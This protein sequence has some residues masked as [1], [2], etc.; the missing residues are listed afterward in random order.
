MR[1]VPAGD[2]AGCAGGRARRHADR[3][4]TRR[5]PSGRASSRRGLDSPRH[6]AFGARGDL[7]VAEAGRGGARRRASSA[8]KARRCMGATGAVTKIDRRGR[9]SRIADGLAVVGEHRP[10]APWAATRSARTASPSSAT[11]RSSITNGGP[12]EPRT[13]TTPTRRSS[14]ET[15]A[16]QNPVANL[17]GTRA[18]DRHARP[19]AAARRH[20]GLRAPRQPRR[21]RR[22]PGG[23][24]QPGRRAPRRRP[25]SSSPTPAATRSTRS[26]CF[27]RVRT[28]RCSRTARPCRT[29]SRRPAD[30]DA[31]RADVGRRG[32]RPPLLRQ[33]AHRLP[34]PARRR[35]RLPRRSDDGRGRPCSRAA[36][37]TSWTW[38][39]AA[40]ARSTCSRSTM[41][42][43]SPGATRARCS[44]S[45]RRRQPSRQDRA[46]G[47]HAAVPRR[48]HGRRRRPLRH[49]QRRLA[50]RRPGDAHPPPRPRPLT[51]GINRAARRHAGHEA[52]HRIRSRRPRRHAARGR[53][54][55][56]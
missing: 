36:S 40:T 5:G 38:R 6:L 52:A 14:R 17:F 46:A 37:P 50:G 24:L 26:T 47:R 8:A 16:A 44:R 33:P 4:R 15:L 13:P 30:P 45:T 20:L 51:P 2:V 35:E 18:A 34:V 55:L 3:R 23:R 22:Q 48:A 53:L 11:T 49:D 19:A 41:T 31:G 12:T 25:A 39:S 27:G 1:S 7:F 28:S 42:A 10:D 32:P 56:R 29:R 54:R 9:Q 21:R 43:C